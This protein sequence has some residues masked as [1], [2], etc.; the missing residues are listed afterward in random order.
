MPCR[1]PGLPPRLPAQARTMTSRAPREVLARPQLRLTVIAKSR[2][3]PDGKEADAQRRAGFG[4]AWA[5]LD[6]AE[7]SDYR[8]ELTAPT[9]A[10]A[11]AVVRSARDV[12]RPRR[13]PLAVI[14]LTFSVDIDSDRACRPLSEPRKNPLFPAG[15]RSRGGE[16]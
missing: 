5:D 9:V 14:V 6:T 13:L 2:S 11:G 4:R 8:E 3:H 12:A 1:Q 7:K 16:I 10:G 15:S